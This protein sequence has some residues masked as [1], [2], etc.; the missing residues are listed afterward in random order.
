MGV[1]LRH[2][3]VRVR[4]DVHLKQLEAGGQGG[5]QRVFRFALR[6]KLQRVLDPPIANVVQSEQVPAVAG[7]DVFAELQND[8]TV[9]HGVARLVVPLVVVEILPD[10]GLHIVHRPDGDFLYLGGEVARRVLRHVVEV[11]AGGGFQAGDVDGG[12]GI[13]VPDGHRA[14]FGGAAAV[15]HLELGVLALQLGG[16]GAALLIQDVVLVQG[17]ALVV[18]Q[19]V[20]LALGDHRPVDG[21]RLVQPGGQGDGRLRLG[22]RVG[23]G[24]GVEHGGRA[25]LSAELEGLDLGAVHAVGV[26]EPQVQGVVL[27]LLQPVA[28]VDDPLGVLHH[29]HHAVAQVAG[30]G[31]GLHVVGGGRLAAL[32]Q[33]SVVQLAALGGHYGNL[34][35]GVG[36]QGHIGVAL[37]EGGHGAVRGGEGDHLHGAAPALAVH[38]HGGQV[39]GAAGGQAADLGADLRVGGGGGH[40]AVLDGQG[41]VGGRG[42]QVVGLNGAI[43]NAAHRPVDRPPLVGGEQALEPGGGHVVGHRVAGEDPGV[44]G[45]LLRRGGV[46]LNAVDDAGDAGADVDVVRQH[47]HVGAGGVDV[48]LADVPLAGD[49]GCHVQV[50]LLD[51][52]VP[53]QLDAGVHRVLVHGQ[54]L[55]RALGHL[56]GGAGGLVHHLFDPAGQVQVYPVLAVQGDVHQALVVGVVVLQIG[57][58]AHGGAG[59]VGNAVRPDGDVLVLH[60]VHQHLV[61][62]DVAHDHAGVA[63]FA[64]A[65]AADDDPAQNVHVLQQ[66]AAQAHAAGD[67]QVAAD[68]GVP[69]GDSGGGDGDVAEHAAQAVHALLLDG[70]AD[71]LGDEDGHLGLGHRVLGSEGVV[72]VAGDDIVVHGGP[73]DAP[74]PGADVPA[75]GEGQALAGRLL[76]HHVFPQDEHRLLP[77]EGGVGGGGGGGGAR[78]ITGVVGDGDIVIE[79]V[80]D[81]HVGKGDAPRLVIAVS[82]VDDAGEVGPGDGGVRVADLVGPDDAPVHQLVQV[83]V[84]P[85][86]GGGQ[87]QPRRQAE[88]HRR[89]QQQ[90]ERPLLPCAAAACFGSMGHMWFSFLLSGG[91]A[92]K[93]ARLCGGITRFQEVRIWM[94]NTALRMRASS[95][96][97]RSTNLAA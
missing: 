29:V 4:G 37:G 7:G 59:D 11:V 6:Q 25:V 19:G 80:V 90:A 96:W 24:I 76:H 35:H 87:G 48:Q 55:D 34:G 56:H 64:L 85:V 47:G 21:A 83:F 73:D 1:P 61:G 91:R 27:Q 15:L 39:V 69:Q 41:A 97:I 45:N 79:P 2:R 66:D 77:G 38:Q 10:Q 46:H 31:G 20:G 9:G 71:A 74:G 33:H 68:G 60:V 94:L 51:L 18:G 50:Q 67:V 5:I 40:G 72:R 36:H 42:H 78:H 70:G 81:L 62:G 49:V 17:V 75:V 53:V 84:G 88:G 23:V 82:P 14:P 57:G 32:G 16:D 93:P 13:G 44:A 3:R 22:G 65:G 52:G 86:G 54:L 92:R 63:G 28:D 26:G 95:S 30:D 89:G 43:G 58:G 12:V 8:V